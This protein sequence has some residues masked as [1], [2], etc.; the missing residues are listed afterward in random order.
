[1]LLTCKVR[2]WPTQKQKHVLWD[3]SEKCRLLY[4]FSLQARKQD[5]LLQYQKEKNKQNFITYQQQSRALPEIKRT[6]P[7]Y[8]W[9][10]SKV[11]QQVLKKLD[12]NFRSFLSLRKKGD[13]NA[14]PPHFKGKHFFFTLCYNQSGFSISRGMLHLSHNHPWGIPLDFRMPRYYNGFEQVKQ[15]EIKQER[16]RK[17]FACITYIMESP[18]YKD[19]G[20]YQAID[21]G[22]INIVSAV[23]LHFKFIQIKNRRADMFWKRKME[24]AQSKRD[25][26]KQHS[27]R[28]ERYHTK[29]GQMKRKCAHQMRDYQHKISKKIVNNTRA[30]TII[31][32]DLNVKQMAKKQQGTGNARKTKACRTLHHSVHNTGSLGRFTQFLT[33]KAERAGKRVIRIDESYTSQKCFA[34]GKRV[35]RA[36][37]ERVITCDCGTRMDRDLNA[38]LNLLERFLNQKYQLKFLSHQPS[39]TEESFRERLD[40]LRYTVPSLLEAR[41]GELVVNGNIIFK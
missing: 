8:R 25:H 20:L 5:W 26:C 31:F 27:H 39:M 41:D 34:C 28:W 13:V 6:Y 21:L 11:L 17:W 37:S 14:R 33:Y 35:K 19:N 15:V 9:V 22:V 12:E 40:L 16:K 24:Q 7:E 30:N 2:V 1:M 38:A 3:L 36:L 23:N 10:Y 18:P 32:G 29:L 4:N